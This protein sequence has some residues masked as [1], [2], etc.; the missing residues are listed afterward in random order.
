MADANTT[1]TPDGGTTPPADDKTGKN[2]G[3][4]KT[5]TQ[6]EVN[7]IV[8]E[9]INEVSSKTDETVAKRI[10]EAQAEWERKAKLSDEQRASEA[11]KA[12][13]A[14]LDEK[15][16]QITL[17]ENRASAI[18]KLVEKKI[19]TEVVDYLVG[20]DMDKTTSNIDKFETV[21]NKA[22]ETAVET[23]LKGSTPPDLK[24]G[25]SKGTERKQPAYMQ[26][27]ATVL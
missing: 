18:E 26:P 4:S 27:N 6:E 10:Q 11:Q 15:D 9:R 16:R 20:I 17:R 23:K 7:K 14:E 19:P 22:V 12:K 24:G 1:Q 21:F 5:F 2:G 13:E 8:S 25:K 3:D